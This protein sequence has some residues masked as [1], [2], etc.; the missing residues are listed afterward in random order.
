MVLQPARTP[1]ARQCILHGPNGERTPNAL[2]PALLA[3]K[4]LPTRPL[5]V[6]LMRGLPTCCVTTGV[7]PVK[8]AVRKGV[9][10][11]MVTR[12]LPPVA[13][14]HSKVMPISLYS[15]T[16]RLVKPSTAVIVR[17]RS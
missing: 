9:P 6:P 5:P 15:T 8:R 13:A 12:M 10:C 1:Q 7:T 3:L 4:V 11:S 14:S 17:L 16:R 2:A